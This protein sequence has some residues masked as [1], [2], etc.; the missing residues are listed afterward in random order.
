M[1]SGKN[2]SCGMDYAAKTNRAETTPMFVGTVQMDYFAEKLHHQER[3][4]AEVEPVI[5]IE[6][7]LK[8]DH[9]QQGG[10]IQKFCLYD[11]AP[12]T[13]SGDI[14]QILRDNIPVFSASNL[15]DD[16]HS[17][18]VSAELLGRHHQDSEGYTEKFPRQQKQNL[19]CLAQ[20]LSEER[21]E[22]TSGQRVGSIEQRRTSVTQEKQ[23]GASSA[24]RATSLTT[25]EVPFLAIPGPSL[26]SPE[27]PL[28]RS[29]VEDAP[30]LRSI[31]ELVKDTATSDLQ[32][33]GKCVASADAKFSFDR[34]KMP[35]PLA[36][37]LPFWE[38]QPDAVLLVPEWW[39]GKHPSRTLQSFPR[40][41][42]S[43]PCPSLPEHHSGEALRR[44]LASTRD[45]LRHRSMQLP[46]TSPGSGER[47]CTISRQLLFRRWSI[48]SLNSFT[49]TACN[50]ACIASRLSRQ[51]VW[52]G[53]LRYGHICQGQIPHRDLFTVYSIGSPGKSGLMTVLRV[54]P[55]WRQMG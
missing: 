36:H 34:I 2:N 11:G 16:G 30:E 40:A 33:R 7:E 28:F 25:Y 14:F 49:P 51:A 18:T 9:D 8:F 31:H 41:L 10:V 12:I 27:R 38:V 46:S 54:T 55:Q 47:K 24:L 17:Q 42:S 1:S 35:P 52:S 21:R 50:T 53:H 44:V 4:Q 19:R 37:N 43:T 23:E 39:G 13:S 22:R 48:V 3:I 6:G 20:S 26:E 45:K 15:L 32:L 5:E 29:L